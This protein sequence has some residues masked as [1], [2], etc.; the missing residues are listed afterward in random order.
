MTHSFL[1]P[2]SANRR[3]NM[4]SLVTVKG[5]NPGQAFSLH[6]ET[7]SIGRQPDVDIYLESLA[8]SRQHARILRQNGGFFIEDLGSSNGTYLNGEKIQQRRPLGEE[9]MVQ[10]GPYLL[11]LRPDPSASG[12]ETNSF[13]RHRIQAQASNQTLYAGNASHKLQVVLEIAQ[14]LGH[15]LELDPLLNQLL[16]HL[17]RLFTQADRGLILLCK[18][19]Q[20][21]LQAQ[22]SRLPT[23]AGDPQYSKTIVRRALDEGVGLLSEDVADD[24]SLPPSSTM[25]S[26]QLRSF[27][28]VPLLGRDQRRLGVIQL[29]CM[30]PGQGFRREDLEVLTALSIPVGVVLENAALHA[31]QMRQARMHQDLLLAREIQQAFLPT[32]FAGLARQGIDVYAHM[33]PAWEVSGDLYDFFQLPDGRLAFF[34][35]DVSGKG[36]PAALFMIEVRTLIR[37]LAPLASGPAD[38]LTRL[39]QALVADNPTALF[40][41]LAH[42]IYDHRDG[43]VVVAIGGHPTPLLREPSGEVRPL[44]L[45]LSPFLGSSALSPVYSDT[46]ITLAEGETL[47]FYTDGFTDAFSPDGSTMFG[48]KH[49]GEALGGLRTALPLDQCAQEASAALQSFTGKPEL[50]DDQ[51]LFLLRRRSSLP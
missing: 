25:L 48:V 47:I 27:L 51:T 18:G 50:Q 40:V 16:D 26:L 41:T 29:D 12:M 42:G 44:D 8:V 24:R 19:D 21:V 30:R 23:L 20:L 49:L 32:D 17:L 9:D 7:T 5:P 38:L 3:D 13:I 4:A 35:G 46:R 6:G 34:L 10:I 33:Q 43:S 11:A 28:C 36:T 37:H 39:N 22:R 31:E 1:A 14:N 2:K 45:P 15:T